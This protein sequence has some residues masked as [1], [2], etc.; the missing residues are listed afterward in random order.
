MATTNPITGDSISTRF[1]DKEAQ[2]KFDQS[3]DAIFGVKKKTNGGWTPPPIK[4]AALCDVC[5]KDL[6]TTQECAWTSCP[7]NWD[8]KRA[9][10]I[11]S[12]GNIGYEQ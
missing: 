7:K 4:T 3:F 5:G 10:I 8:E 1:G 11:G 2:E 6:N 12:N 9:D